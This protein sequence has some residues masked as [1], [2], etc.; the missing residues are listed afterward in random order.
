MSGEHV[1]HE[2]AGGW[3]VEWVAET[4]STN[5]DL[6]AAADAGTAR[7]RSAL[8]TDHQTAGRGRLDRRWSAPPGENLLVS[9]LF[10][11]VPERPAQLTQVVGLAV[12]DAIEQL[13]GDRVASLGLKWPND[14][15]VDGRKAAGVLA[16]QAPNG[17]V[18]VGAGV[19]LGWAPDGAARLGDVDPDGFLLTVLDAFDALPDD[20]SELYRASLATL[21]RRVRVE[22]PTDAIVGTAIDV[23]AH[24][25]LVVLD[26]CAISHHIEAG[27]V[28]HLR[29]AP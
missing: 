5:D 26:E 9:L 24:G 11:D 28:I 8:R 3:H 2:T 17:A 20:V 19:N 25:R 21:G 22:R 6:L 14:V 1:I 27:D 10:T 16:Q 18:V 15:L 29:P 4:G 12:V 13:A 7:H 23:D